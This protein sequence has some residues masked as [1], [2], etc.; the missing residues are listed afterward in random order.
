MREGGGVSGGRRGGRWG[1]GGRGGL[2]D[3]V[4]RSGSG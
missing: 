1:T 2:R 4:P 3:L